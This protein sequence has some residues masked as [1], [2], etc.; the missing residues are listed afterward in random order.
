MAGAAAAGGM[1]PPP[2]QRRRLPGLPV[3]LLLPFLIL[4]AAGVWGGGVPERGPGG[5][6]AGSGAATAPGAAWPENGT[7][8][9]THGQLPGAR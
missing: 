5:V 6:T 8:G 1:N 7:S 9:L 4:E 3:L 2:G